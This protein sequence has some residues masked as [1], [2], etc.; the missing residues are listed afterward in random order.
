MRPAP[1]TLLW[2]VA[3]DMRL[4]WR[5][6]GDV[7]VNWP[8]S[9]RLMLAALIVTLMHV[10]AYGAFKFAARLPDTSSDPSIGMP[11]DTSVGLMVL[12]GVFLW[13]VSQGLLGAARALYQRG[14]LELLLTSPIAPWKPVAARAVSIAGSSLGS[15][16]AF[17]I[18]AANVGAYLYGPHWLSAYVV[19]AALA[20]AGTAVGFLIAVGLFHVVG[21]R[22]ARIVAQVSAAVIAGAFVLGVQILTIL[23]DD[24]ATAVREWMS[25]AG[26]VLPDVGLMDAAAAIVRGDALAVA[27]ALAMSVAAFLLALQLSSPAFAAAAAVAA[28]TAAAPSRAVARPFR[29]GAFAALRIKE[30][31]LLMRDPNL[32]AQLGLQVIYTLP[33]AVILLKNPSGLDPG[34]A[35]LPLVVVLASQVSASLSWLTISGEDAPEL[36]STAPLPRAY[37]EVAKLTA[38]FVPLLVILALPFAALAFVAPNMLPYA[39]VFGAM[40]AG[41]TALLNF[42][43]PMPGNRRGMLRRHHQS[44]VVALAE[45]GL[46]LLWALAT[47]IALKNVYAT[48]VPVALILLLLWCFNPRTT[49]RG[50]RTI[51][52]ARPVGALAEMPIK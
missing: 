18:P 20:L 49:K 46:T 40:A 52:A 5:M 30:R 12:V 33:L 32:F 43:H 37:P 28:G 14:E 17:I 25:R 48:I 36:L 44:K 8:L 22:G 26:A 11:F 6:L 41:S 35:L 24:M 4:N 3:N 42:W 19:S 13:M 10:A 47:M 29:E 50:K 1:G 34:V 31:R 51:P 7:L 27:V 16:A 2:L 21:P 45:H 23:P 9:V 38:V 39:V 15:L